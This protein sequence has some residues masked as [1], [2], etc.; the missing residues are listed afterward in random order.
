MP[1]SVEKAKERHGGMA[2]LLVV[3]SWNLHSMGEFRE[4][5]LMRLPTPHEERDDREEN[6]MCDCRQQW[7][8]GIVEV[9]NRLE[10]V[11]A[12]VP[13]CLSAFVP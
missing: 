4:H 1:V 2:N 3:N 9:E 12:L 8:V 11:T 5:T 10:R 13:F 6:M 7:G